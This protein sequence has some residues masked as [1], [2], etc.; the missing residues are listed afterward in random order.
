MDAEGLSQ[1]LALG[2]QS[3]VLP[4]TVSAGVSGLEDQSCVGMQAPLEVWEAPKSS[5]W[6]RWADSSALSQQESQGK[7]GAQRSQMGR[8][9]R[10][11]LW[12]AIRRPTRVGKRG[13]GGSCYLVGL[14][15]WKEW[16]VNAF[17]NLFSWGSHRAE[18]ITAVQKEP[19]RKSWALSPQ[20]SPLRARVSFTWGRT[21]SSALS[22]QTNFDL[23]LGVT[24]KIIQIPQR[25]TP[26]SKESKRE[27]KLSNTEP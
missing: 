23:Q 21:V 4:R 26:D 9:G 25:T 27:N 11:P 24:A 16:V 12:K 17:F 22:Q 6:F 14:T 8:R 10:L 3:P 2:R 5:C 19:A 20:T 7:G 18:L 15:L 1:P 13:L